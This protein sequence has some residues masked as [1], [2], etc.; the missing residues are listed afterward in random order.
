MINFILLHW[1][2]ILA[3]YGGLVAV[4]TSVVKFTP[5]TK[6]DQIVAKIIKVL[7]YFSTAFTK[8]DAQKLK[9]K[10]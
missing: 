7:D 6:D 1:E 5:T 10:E 4:S 8:A 2:E 3:I 9:D